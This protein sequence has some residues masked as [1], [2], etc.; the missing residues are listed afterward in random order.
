LPRFDVGGEAFAWGVEFW[1]MLL[2]VKEKKNFALLN[3]LNWSELGLNW[4]S[5]ICYQ[6][7]IAPKQQSAPSPFQEKGGKERESV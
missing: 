4:D 1:R 2:K 6:F 3:F 5:L 7:L